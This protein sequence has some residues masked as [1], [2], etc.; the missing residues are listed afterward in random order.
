MAAEAVQMRS[1]RYLVH[2][3]PQQEATFSRWRAGSTWFY[4]E[5]ARSQRD[6]WK[7]HVKAESRY[8]L[9]AAVRAARESGC[10]FW[11]QGQDHLLSA[12][13]SV[14]LHGAVRELAAS[15]SRHLKMRAEGRRSSPPGFRSVRRGGSVSWQVQ[16]KGGPK[17]AVKIVMYSAG[18]WAMASLFREL[19]PV[20]I[21]Y[22]RPMPEDALVGNIILGADDLGRHWIVLQYETALAE[23]AARTGITG[24]DR[25]VA[26]TLMTAGGNFYNAPRLSPGQESRMCRLQRALARKRRLSP[27]RHDRWAAGSNGRPRLIRGKCPPPLA[28]EDCH[29]WKHSRRYQ[30]CKHSY[31]KLSQRM[32]NQR[33]DGAHKVSRMLARSFSTVV[34]EDLNV[35]GMT[36]S[37]KGDEENPGSHVRQKAGLN[38]GILAS[39]WHQIESL[40]AYKTSVAKVPAHHTSQ[41]CPCCGFTDKGNRPSRD[42]FRCVSCGLSGHADVI[43]AQN[44]RDRYLSLTAPARGA[45]AREI[46]V[47]AREQPV[48]CHHHDHRECHRHA[49]SPGEHPHTAQEICIPVMPAAPLL[50]AP[51]GIRTARIV[52]GKARSRTRKTATP[53]NGIRM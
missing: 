24:A 50:P 41:A 8:D 32:K 13:P 33:T 39:N 43:A 40:T 37:A 23:K 21:R 5:A 25:G 53:V 27:C 15:W 19:G 9:A 35:S 45:E 14:I 18:R 16:D 48:N 2:F 3:T 51:W 7:H 12:V 31:L 4:N 1:Q 22:H 46:C 52:P 36:A 26:V 42:R 47:P 6:R 30:A 49:L 17:P 38:R 20:K 28:A 44:I 34:M 10:T 11:H 29:C